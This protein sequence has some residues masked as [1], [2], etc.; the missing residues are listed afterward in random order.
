MMPA[1]VDQTP[2]DGEAMA[3]YR[4]TG[5]DCPSCAARIEKA[6]RHVAGV[7]E[8]KVSM[9][10]QV[11]SLSVDRTVRL[12][13]VL[14]AETALGYRVDRIGSEVRAAGDGDE[15]QRDLS[16][17]APADNTWVCSPEKSFQAHY[18]GRPI[19]LLHAMNSSPLNN[20]D[21]RPSCHC[22]A[23]W[24]IQRD[25]PRVGMVL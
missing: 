17:F 14:G 10:S 25:V 11:L 9:A 7:A 21:V 6:A 20:R 2:P 1:N 13:D 12:D 8:A 4:V 18:R 24:N 3:R 22:S 23:R 15:L 16:H 19:D 5:M